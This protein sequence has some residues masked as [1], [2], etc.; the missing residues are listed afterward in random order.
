[1]YTPSVAEHIAAGALVLHCR[2]R[3][4]TVAC[5]DRQTV[6]VTVSV[7]ARLPIETSARTR[8]RHEIDSLASRGSKRARLVTHG[9]APDELIELIVHLQWLGYG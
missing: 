6:C 2:S 5:V 7:C 1:M 4:V 3:T 9:E 8:S